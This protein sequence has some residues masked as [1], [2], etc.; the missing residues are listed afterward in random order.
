MILSS[1]C[2][3]S[4]PTVKNV[5]GDRVGSVIFGVIASYSLR[6]GFRERCLVPSQVQLRQYRWKFC[7]VG[8]QE[9][10]RTRSVEMAGRPAVRVRCSLAVAGGGFALFS[11]LRGPGYPAFLFPLLQY[12]PSGVALVFVGATVAPSR[13]V[14]T[15]IAL[16]ALWMPSMWI[17]HVFGQTS[18]GLTNCMHATGDSIGLLVGVALIIRQVGQSNG[19]ATAAPLT[20]SDESPTS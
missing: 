11:F 1:R 4:E 6:V 13:K 5:S 10:I 14:P 3:T 2:R 18:P 7:R 17:V 16:T 20:V 12:L 9:T 19:E 15:S 8:H